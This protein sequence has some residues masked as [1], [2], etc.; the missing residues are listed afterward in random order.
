MDLFLRGQRALVTGSTSGI[1][2]QIGKTLAQEG[3]QVIVHGRRALEVD[4]VV[5]EIR[6]AGGSAVAAIGDLGNDTEA[7]KVTEIAL[8]AFGGVDILLNNAGAFPRNLWMQ[9]SAAEWVELY[10]ANVGRSFA[11]SR[12]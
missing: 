11:W 12:S 2:K 6:E 1:G 8:A 5:R 10:N 4:R 9:S 7:K 3:V